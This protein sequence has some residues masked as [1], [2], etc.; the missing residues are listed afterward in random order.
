[1]TKRLNN[2]Q[3]GCCAE[4]V[5][6]EQHL[7]RSTE[8]AGRL[9]AWRRGGVG[10]AWW[11]GGPGGEGSVVELAAGGGMIAPRF[12]SSRSA[13]RPCALYSAQYFQPKRSLTAGAFPVQPRR[14]MVFPVF[15][16]LLWYH[17]LF[18][19]IHKQEM[20]PQASGIWRLTLSMPEH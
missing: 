13:C 6:V 19:P 9:G 4:R 1:M 17:L 2:E 8:A 7:E 18:L 5:H 16:K 3:Q 12:S 20:F 14:R 10:G 15:T 11:R